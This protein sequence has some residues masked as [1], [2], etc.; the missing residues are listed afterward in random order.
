[1]EFSPIDFAKFAEACGGKGYSIKK[2]SEAKSIIHE[3]M[4]QK[5]PTLIEAYADPFEH[6]CRQK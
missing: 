4:R 2:T 6:L 5:R 1:V 3:A